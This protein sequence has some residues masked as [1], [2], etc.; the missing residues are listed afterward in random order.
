[1]E[2]KV[3]TFGRK[4]KLISNV[5]TRTLPVTALMSETDEVIGSHPQDILEARGSVFIIIIIIYKSAYR[6]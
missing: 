3:K 5:V 2:S 4:T 1:M 6:R